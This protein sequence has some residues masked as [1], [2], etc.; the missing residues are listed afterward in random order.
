MIS[1]NSTFLLF[2]ATLLG[3]GSF[4]SAQAADPNPR[5]VPE[6]R[7]ITEPRHETFNDYVVHYTA[8][9]TTELTAEVARA[10]GI[11]RGESLAMLN[12]TVLLRDD[13]EE[14]EPVTADIEVEAT[15]LAGQLQGIAIRE[16]RDGEAIYY[17]GEFTVAH[18]EILTFDVH[19]RPH[20]VE[21]EHEFSFQQQFFTD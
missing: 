7:E 5:P 18:E 12:I 21:V 20:G 6:A 17:I 14:R 11:S 2:L 8:Q 16:V 19:V 15:N 10:L 4:T 3:A 13:A 1:R 9:M